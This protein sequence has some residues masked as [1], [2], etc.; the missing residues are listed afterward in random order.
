MHRDIT[1]AKALGAFTPRGFCPA[2]EDDLQDGRTRLIEWGRLIGPATLPRRK[3]QAA[4]NGCWRC[5][6]EGF[7]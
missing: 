3:A 2:R 1:G 4:K 7:S 5:A 6:G